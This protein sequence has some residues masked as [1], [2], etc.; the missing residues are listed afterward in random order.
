MVS[1]LKIGIIDYSFCNINSVLS[2]CHD[3]TRNV[4][5]ITK[6]QKIKNFDKLILPGVGNLNLRY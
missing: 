3:V 6:P 1:N 4:E 2:A 5:V